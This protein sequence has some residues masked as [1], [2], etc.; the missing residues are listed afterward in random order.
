[1][2][3]F[4][5]EE[6]REVALGA[7]MFPNLAV[8]SLEACSG[9]GTHRHR[10]GATLGLQIRVVRVDPDMTELVSDNCL[11]LVLIQ[12]SEKPLVEL[13][14][15]RAWVAVE[16]LDRD[17]QAVGRHDLGRNGGVDPEFGLE[18]VNQFL[19][20]NCAGWLAGVHL[21]GKADDDDGKAH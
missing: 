2:S 8:D 14:P 13:H 3:L 1:M 16:G 12:G 15:K 4:G 19:K 18:T 20:R 11:Q 5:S 7:L 9:N 21:D 6:A 17:Q 10:V